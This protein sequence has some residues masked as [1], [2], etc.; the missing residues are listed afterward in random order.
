MTNIPSPPSTALN[1]IAWTQAVAIAAG[2]PYQLTKL[3]WV[4]ETA[5]ERS[6]P[7]K[8]YFELIKAVYQYENSS[9]LGDLYP[10]P[11][12][13]L[14]AIA[15]QLSKGYQALR[16]YPDE[17]FPG[18]RSFI[19]GGRAYTRFLKRDFETDPLP[20]TPSGKP[21][22]FHDDLN[23]WSK[24]PLEMLLIWA[25]L[26]SQS[27][28]EIY[29]LLDK[30]ISVNKTATHAVHQMPSWGKAGRKPKRKRMF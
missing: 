13:L 4:D 8:N 6:K 14:D 7:L 30:V 20:P 1:R 28:E 2:L 12:Y 15:T 23:Q 10:S 25:K 22:I 27:S 24:I 17:E 18:R 11:V 21:S 5:Q 9:F 19:A 29:E 26:L 3:E 16:A